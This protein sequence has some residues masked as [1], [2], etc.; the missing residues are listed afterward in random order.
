VQIALHAYPEF[1]ITQCASAKPMESGSGE[2]EESSE[3]GS[4]SDDDDKEKGGEKVSLHICQ[5]CLH[6]LGWS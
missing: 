3:S 2:D 6:A 5:S 1:D 4:G